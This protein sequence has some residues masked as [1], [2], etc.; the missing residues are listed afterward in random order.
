MRRRERD[1]GENFYVYL[2][3]YSYVRLIYKNLTI[4]DKGYVL[5]FSRLFVCHVS[6]MRDVGSGVR[7]PRYEGGISD[8]D[9]TRRSLVVETQRIRG[10][11]D[12]LFEDSHWWRDEDRGLVKEKVDVNKNFPKSSPTRTL[13]QPSRR[14]STVHR[15]VGDF[16]RVLKFVRECRFDKKGEEGRRD[17]CSA[18]TVLRP[19]GLPDSERPE[20]LI[21]LFVASLSLMSD[22]SRCSQPDFTTRG[23]KDKSFYTLR[24]GCDG[25]RNPV[26]H[27][28]H[29]P[30][31]G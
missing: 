20:G 13:S 28:S 17:L 3:V 31:S 7:G 23:S 12:P 14:L 18:L 25:K 15:P 1:N 27:T 2:Y 5:K 10:R 24:F 22:D 9:R 21:F 29:P 30:H 16:R 4:T 8:K 19:K 26:H 11:V 6:L